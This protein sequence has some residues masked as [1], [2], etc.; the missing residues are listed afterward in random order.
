[1]SLKALLLTSCLPLALLAEGGSATD[2]PFGV[3]EQAIGN[4]LSAILERGQ[5]AVQE[6]VHENA[7]AVQRTAINDDKKTEISAFV[8]RFWGGAKVSLWGLSVA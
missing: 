7:S 3:Y 1:M 5:S 8:R 2:D 6:R 4:Q